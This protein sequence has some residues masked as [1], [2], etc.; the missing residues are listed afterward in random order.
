[1]L[2]W[3]VG[4]A[5]ASSCSAGDVD[6][7]GPERGAEGL[8]RNAQVVLREEGALVGLVQAEELVWMV[9][10]E[11]SSR[12]AL[13]TS[14]IAGDP[15]TRVLAVRADAPFPAG[16]DVELWT[17]QGDLVTSF[18]IGEVLDETPPRWTGAYQADV[19]HLPFPAGSLRLEFEFEG[20]S[21]DSGPIT[22][23]LVPLVE[24]PVLASA[25]SRVTASY[26]ASCGGDDA[27]SEPRNRAYELTIFDA[28]GNS[29]PGG[30]VEAC[31]CTSAPAGWSGGLGLALAFG[32][33]L[34]TRRER[35]GAHPRD[36]REGA[37][38]A[39]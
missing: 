31:G 1:M 26:G 33:F 27:I 10:G 11:A 37:R 34:A 13:A 28:A 21:D 7:L 23:L 18:G 32:W 39:C 19:I 16:A 20:L 35:P 17:T 12:A 9:A 25:T 5:S 15:P 6:V 36:G 4:E 24:G 22:L 38:V 29:T 3:W 2:A 8:P 14:W 30:V